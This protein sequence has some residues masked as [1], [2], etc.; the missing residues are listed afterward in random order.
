MP[1]SVVVSSVSATFFTYFRLC[2]NP[3]LC[4][5]VSAGDVSSGKAELA[6]I[7]AQAAIAVLALLVVA[8]ADGSGFANMVVV[9]SVVV[10]TLTSRPGLF[11]AARHQRVRL[12]TARSGS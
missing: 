1:S 9:V 2:S 5:G 6:A 12:C 8:V 11:T 4:E 7:A 10:Q 3:R